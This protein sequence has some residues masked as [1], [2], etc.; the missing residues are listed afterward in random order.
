MRTQSRPVQNAKCCARA[1]SALLRL[2]ENT[3]NHMSQRARQDLITSAQHEVTDAK[4]NARAAAAALAY[5]RNTAGVLDPE[6]QAPIQYELVS[7][8]QD[9]LIQA[10]SDR[11]Q[12]VAVA[13]QSEQIPALDARIH[14]IETR[15]AE[16]TGLAAGNRKK[17]LAAAGEEYERLA[18][19]ADFAAKRLAAA[20][21]SLEQA[22]IEAQRKSSYVETIV[23]PNSPD[24]ATEPRRL[25]GIVTVLAFSLIVWG[26][27]TM[28]IAG[29]REHRA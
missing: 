11:R 10:R 1:A 16:Q 28:L 21:A 17:S 22:E 26:V 7:K 5:Y 25:R 2:A 18:L 24:K 15:L 3:V 9:E 20:L 13:P 23:E 12:L 8:L 19:D 27:V 4:T 29:I 14:E 6:K